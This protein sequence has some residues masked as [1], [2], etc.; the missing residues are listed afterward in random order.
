MHRSRLRNKWEDWR[1]R[2][3]GKRPYRCRSCSWR[4]WGVDRG[5][6]P[7]DDE[8]VMPEPPNLVAIGLARRDRRQDVDLA[9]LDAST[10]HDDERT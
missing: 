5:T 8:V 6:P 1:Q 7:A 2:V 4:G 9:A 10:R 3:T